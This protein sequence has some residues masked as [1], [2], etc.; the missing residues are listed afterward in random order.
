MNS[1]ID[2]PVAG[3][4]PEE[5]Y[6]RLGQLLQRNQVSAAEDHA[7]RALAQHGKDLRLQHDLAIVLAKQRKFAESEQI[8][9]EVTQQAPLWAE[10]L[11]NLG[12]L[13]QDTGRLELAEDAFR[14][15]TSLQSKSANALTRLGHI[16][17]RRDA[18]QES[19]EVLQAALDAE[20]EFIEAYY[21]K[22]LTH[23]DAEQPAEAQQTYETLL[24]KA[25]EHY[26]AINNLGV[27]HESRGNFPEAERY[28]RKATEL[29][30]RTPDG[31]NNLGV[32]LAAQN[33]HGEAIEAYRRALELSPHTPSVLSNLGNALRSEGK[34]DEAVVR[35][36]EAI[37]LRPD[38]AEAYNNLAIVHVQRGEHAAAMECYDQAVYIRP[39]YPEARMNRALDWLA[40]G[41]LAKGWVEYEWRWKH[42]GIRVR[43]YPRPRWDGTDPAGRRLFVYYEQGFGDTFQFVRYVP[44]LHKLGA[45]VILEV[46]KPLVKIVESCPGV[47]TVVAANAPSVPDFDLHVPLMAVPGLLNTRMESIPASVPY[48]FPD[49]E[50]VAQWRQRLPAGDLR[51]GIAWQ[52][53]PDYRGDRL[54]SIPLRHF[55]VLGGIEGVRFVALQKGFGTEQ[56]AEVAEHLSIETYPDMD[57]T[58]GSFMDTAAIMRNVDL[59]ITS[60]TAVPHLA[61]ALGVPVWVAIPAAAD[62][63]WL[64]DREDSPWYPTMRIFRQRHDGDWQA[65]F[66]QIA[67]QLRTRMTSVRSTLRPATQEQRQRARD[68]EKEGAKQAESGDLDEAAR[69]FQK[70][71]DLDPRL[72]SARHNLG[73]IEARRGYLDQAMLHFR[74][75]IELKPDFV[76][77]FANL[78]L[79]FLEKGQFDESI[80][81]FRRALQ[82]G[83]NS[84]ETHN[85]LGVALLER[86]QPDAALASFEQALKVRPEYAE[87]HVNYARALLATG[88]FEDGW[89]ELEWRKH[90]P[91]SRQ[92]SFNQSRWMGLPA[93]EE[94]VLLHAEMGISDT[95]QMVRYAELVKQ[96]ASRVVLECQRELVPLLERCP[97]LDAVVAADDPL[98]QFDF[99]AP[100]LSLPGLFRTSLASIPRKVPYL[101]VDEKL[102][103]H[104]QGRLGQ[105][106]G[107]KVGIA[108]HGRGRP[109]EANGSI[110]LM[111]LEPLRYVP[112][113]SFVSVQHGLGTEQLA[114]VGHR[115]PIV[116]LGPHVNEQRGFLMD[117]AAILACLDL[118]ITC[119]SHIAHLAGA[120]G[121]PV[122]VLLGSA[123]DYRWMLH[124]DDTPW[125]PSMRLFRRPVPG[126]WQQVVRELSTSL[127]EF[128]GHAVPRNVREIFG[129]TDAARQSYRRGR[130]QCVAG[131]WSDA[132]RSFRTALAVDPKLAQAH[133]DLGAILAQHGQVEEGVRHL[134]Q[135]LSLDPEIPE[136]P[137]NLARGLLD[138]RR[139]QDAADA[140]RTGLQ[141]GTRTPWLYNILGSSLAHLGDLQEA[142][143]AFR[144]AL[145][146]DPEF[147]PAQQGLANAL[148]QQRRHS[149]A[150]VEFE[151]ALRLDDQSADL[152][153]N[154]GLTHAELDQAAEAQRCYR[155]AL[156]LNPE[157]AETWN[158][159]GVTLAD[160][161]D[162]A[163]AETALRRVVYYRPSWAEAHRNL[164]IVL[165]LQ[166]KLAEGWEEYEWRWRAGDSRNWRWPAKAWS[167][168]D[169]AGARLLAFAEQGLGDTLQ[170][171]R[172]VKLLEQRGA[173]VYVKAQAALKR[174]L[175][176]CGDIH[177]WVEEDELPEV[178]GALPLL[179]IPRLL[180]TTLENVPA[181]IPYLKPDPQLVEHWRT[182][183]P[184][185]QLRIGIAW[186]GS[187]SYAGDT[188]RSIPLECFAPLAQLP[189]VALVSLQKGQGTEQIESLAEPFEL[190]VFS[191]LD[192]EHGAFMD[193]A[194]II[195]G[196]DL[197]ITSDSAIAHLAGAVGATV[198]MPLGKKNDWRWLRERPDTP[199][200]PNM[201]LFRQ[202]TLGEWSD[203]FQC[204]AQEIQQAWL[205][206]T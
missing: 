50:L 114:A 200:Y 170:F 57:T 18:F 199:W 113:V 39:N 179:S 16:L 45:R 152:Y 61:G 64:H 160:A 121:L 132:I 15:A 119:D 117:T 62:W 36:R 27:L 38:Y 188:W 176:E 155:R 80:A 22:A 123:P 168:S 60:D 157:H 70:A 40:Q 189:D 72:T 156:E 53:N 73:V 93:P 125:Y 194:A 145:E 84:P 25:P 204:M 146:R 24:E 74:R 118:V 31:F 71:A 14:R 42:R 106:P 21:E 77:A 109:G 183:I 94:T 201:R 110:P 101:R 34:L 7:R 55:Q 75:A 86:Q 147:G 184:A 89:R 126:T 108:W 148:R 46:P 43:N 49:P 79:A 23:T 186:Q 172:Y 206:P 63:R 187:P 92:R 182:Q 103:E 30:P 97:Y 196:L 151:K 1:P 98:P 4:L 180:G 51:V 54:R 144:A 173:T 190:T 10:A 29:R 11:I 131:D 3:T 56:I 85:N 203:V 136:A 105:L 163:G 135:A 154:L 202:Q 141:R 124:R 181:E 197:M 107:L 134:Q 171:I 149:E 205:P 6:E 116:D 28:L 65:V 185:A 96:R 90:C 167:G 137:E 177:N 52:G 47:E 81:H 133:H 111:E 178:D 128:G 99:H 100:L 159:L 87:A 102:V 13:Y 83:P 104:W 59:V 166:G 164:A 115:F 5:V 9:L 130:D 112:G 44:I 82:L 153:N 17:R 143:E 32:V 12:K 195:A 192:E 175:R 120:L 37:R 68:L 138:L 198:W 35:L 129:E 162:L 69:S 33:R 139:Y 76:D 19:L 20:P 169:L 122:W 48:L 140:A 41:E 127:A 91:G 142:V 174:L 158:N 161:H 66:E 191:D 88:Q 193:T 8:L 150:I 67:Q 78:G 26:G 95:L 58:A 2:T 165:L